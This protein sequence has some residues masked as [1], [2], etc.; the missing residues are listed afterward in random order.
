[1]QDIQHAAALNRG[2]LKRLLTIT[3]ATSR[4]WQRDVL[5]LLLGHDA[6]MRITEISRIT[7]ADIMRRDGALRVEVSLREAV[8]K[9]CKQRC[10]YLAS[11]R[12]IAAVETYLAW[13][14]AQ[15]IGTELTAAGGYRGLIGGLPLIW[16]S[17]G[18]G[19]SQNTKRRTLQTGELREYKACDSLQVH[20]TKL[21]A[22]AGIARGSSHSGRRSFAAKV[23]ATTGS[24]E[25]V[26]Q[27]LGHEDGDWDVTARY[28]DQDPGIQRSIFANA[29]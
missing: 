9:G 18:R 14:L 2:Q 8:T 5:V 29:V 22:A 6:G 19:M 25:A 21:Y 26:A 4:Y 3:R 17:R 24:M 7:V 10:A 23:L 28:I 15:G 11:K 1:M 20:V 16:S 12:L 13:R 27:L